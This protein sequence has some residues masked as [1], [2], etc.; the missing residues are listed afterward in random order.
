MP[1]EF[2]MLELELF[3][4]C[5]QDPEAEANTPSTTQIPK[6]VTRDSGGDTSS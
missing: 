1:K 6:F 5:L 2:T 3:C 4:Q